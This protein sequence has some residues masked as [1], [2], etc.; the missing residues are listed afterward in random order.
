VDYL[1]GRRLLTQASLVIDH[2]QVHSGSARHRNYAVRREYKAAIRQAGEDTGPTVRETLAREAA[3][4]RLVGGM[5]E[6]IAVRGVMPDFCVWDGERSILVLELIDDAQTLQQ[7]EPERG[8]N[9]PAVSRKL[10][11]LLV[12]LHAHNPRSWPLDTHRFRLPYRYPGALT[13]D[14]RFPTELGRMSGGEQQMMRTLHDHLSFSSHLAALRNDWKQEC[15]IH[16]DLRWSNC[17]VN[18]AVATSG[19]PVVKLIDWEL[20]DC[21][22]RAWD[23][24]G[25]LQSWLHSWVESMPDTGAPTHELVQAARW[26]LADMKPAITAFWSEYVRAAR[27]SQAAAGSLLERSTRYA[28]ARLLQSTLEAMHNESVLTGRGLCGLQLAQYP[29]R[30]R[31]RDVRSARTLLRCCVHCCRRQRPSSESSLA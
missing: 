30:S 29:E 7:L 23:I 4:Y 17:L 9:S 11:R 27:L 19:E 6:A 1:V 16:C 3:W 2:I 24:G 8:V 26:P 12:T 15:I 21:G 13:L 25:V 28:A 14:Q 22:E 5:E 18:D 10:A 31:A 20:V